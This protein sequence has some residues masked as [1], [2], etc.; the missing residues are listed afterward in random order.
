[1]LLAAATA[2]ALFSTVQAAAYLSYSG[3]PIPWEG[4][5]GYTSFLFIVCPQRTPLLC[6]ARTKDFDTTCRF[7][8]LP[9]PPPMKIVAMGPRL[10]VDVRRRE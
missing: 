8:W 7:D 3:E 2:P 6:S 9:N 1:M 4:L 5:A 10:G